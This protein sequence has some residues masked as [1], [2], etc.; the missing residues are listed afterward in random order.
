MK[1]YAFLSRLPSPKSYLDKI[2]LVA[3][4]GIHTPL[5][6]LVLYLA[7]LPAE[8][9]SIIVALLFAT[10]LGTAATLYALYALLAPVSLAAGALRDYRE[11]GATP[12][13][14][15]GFPDRAGRLMDDVQHTAVKLDGVIRSLEDLPT[16]DPLTRLPNRSLLKDRL[17]QALVRSRA[18]RGAPGKVAVLFLDLDDFKAVNDTLGHDAGDELLLAVGNRLR[19]CFGPRDTLAR[20]GG[21]EFVVL[22]EGASAG[23][24]R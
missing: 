20:F 3:F 13:L 5:I 2:L 24:A 19:E 23:E 17:G 1:L 15:V 6:L 21:D 8:T 4:V 22:V 12:E 10:L 14:P 9:G 18:G 7:L 11:R 16:R